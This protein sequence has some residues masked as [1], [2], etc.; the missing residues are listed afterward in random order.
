MALFLKRVEEENDLES[1][2]YLLSFFADDD[3]GISFSVTLKNKKRLKLVNNKVMRLN[4]FNIFETRFKFDIG[5][6]CYCYF[7]VTFDEFIIYA[8]KEKLALLAIALNEIYLYSAKI[9]INLL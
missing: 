7:G 4:Q 9:P 2:A 8:P 3:M 1:G 6:L 5:Y